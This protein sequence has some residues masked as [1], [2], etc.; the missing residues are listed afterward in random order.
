MTPPGQVTYRSTVETDE[1]RPRWA[2]CSRTWARGTAGAAGIAAVVAAITIGGSFG[3]Q[4]HQHAAHRL[5]L[6]GVSLLAVACAVLAVRRRYPAAT[7][8][9]ASSAVSAYF[10]FGF[11][12]GTAFFPLIVAVSG[13]VLAGYRLLAWI[14]C[15]ISYLVIVWG[16]YVGPG[17]KPAGV[18]SGL[19]TAAWPLVVLIGAEVVRAG[20]ERAASAA[21]GR[22]ELERRRASE[23]RLRIAQELHDVLAHNISL[24]SVQAGV[25]LHLM[26]ERPDEAAERARTALTAIRY[27]SKEALGE[28]RSVLGLLRTSSGEEPPLSPAPGMAQLGDLTLRATA[29]GLSVRTDIT[30]GERPLPA[31]TDLAAYRI[32]QEALTNVIR[33]AGATHV[34]VRVSYGDASLGIDVEDDGAAAS[35]PAGGEL[36]AGG[37]LPAAGNPAARA[38]ADDGAA[39]RTGPGDRTGGG[40][41]IA[42]MRE[43]ARLLG[44]E[45][46]ARPL[47]GRGFLVRARLPLTARDRGTATDHPAG[48]AGQL[49]GTSGPAGVSGPAGSGDV[50]SRLARGA[51]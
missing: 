16:G 8:L 37:K 24:I 18:V 50:G 1:R 42:G 39:R 11:S 10:A 32:V 26:D 15:A 36:G 23:E 35:A 2:W 31:G 44:G 43:R 29:A 17:H 30:G 34:T 48:N 9:I 19:T 4:S 3:A 21:R 7:L 46:S 33:H 6:L 20:R 40:N 47:P 12:W 22:A 41:G 27:A 14:T 51:T 49:T 28:L 45:L 13:A 5:N 38:K 25:A